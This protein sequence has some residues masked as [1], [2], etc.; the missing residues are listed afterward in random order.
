M[1]LVNYADDTNVLLK[2]KLLSNLCS[3]GADTF[4]K[5]L[6]WFKRNKLTLNMNK[7]Q[8]VVFNNVQR[9]SNRRSIILDNTV[10]S[11]SNHTKF[12]GLLIDHQ[13]KW[14]YHIELLCKK[15]SKVCY[16]LRELRKVV[17]YKALRTL[18]FGNFYSLMKYGLI[19]WG[20]SGSSNTV[21]VIQK[22]AVRLLMNMKP[23][24]SCRGVFKK[25][26]M[27]TLPS[28]FIYD[29]LCFFKSN[30]KSFHKFSATNNS[31]YNLRSYDLHYPRHNTSKYEKGCL[32]SSIKF[33]NAL[34][35]YFKNIFYTPLFNKQLKT[36]LI[37]LEC[38]STSEFFE[39]C[40]KPINMTE[41]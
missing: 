5:L 41:L 2:N 36:F 38:Y 24:D 7:T 23:T 40:N 14:T 20:S 17:S 37:S 28:L 13:L 12:L 3:D 35:H 18:Y 33:F 26:G 21:F 6:D 39:A 15:L 8:C 4:H 11:F 32:Y 29:S 34:P 31:T 27:L 30:L 25:L 10:V 1:S 22:R 9:K 16:A 19:F